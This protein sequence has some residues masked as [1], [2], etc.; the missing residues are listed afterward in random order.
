MG[1]ALYSQTY[2]APAPVVTIRTEPEITPQPCE[3]WS[4]W[5]HF[6]PDSE[7]FFQDAEYEAFID[8]AQYAREQLA[9]ARAD[10]LNDADGDAASDASESSEGG[11]SAGN[12]ESPM[13]VGADDPAVLIA[14]IYT[15][16]SARWSNGSADAVSPTDP[17]WSPQT[18][19]SVNT[20][21]SS[22]PALFSAS[23]PASE[24]SPAFIPPPL[25]HH[26]TRSPMLRRMPP[27]T[28]ITITRTQTQTRV[29]DADDV[30]FLM[31]SPTPDSSAPSTPLPGDATFF[32]PQSLLTPSPPPS[33]TPR[34]YAWQQYT[35]PTVA[36]PVSPTR[37]RSVARDG[38]L[39]NP[40]ARMSYIRIDAP[41]ARIRIPNT[42]M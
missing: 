29:S 10:N 15:N 6:D 1:R 11:V 17:E 40:R 4:S 33:V 30:D 9:S 38:P 18:A 7:E 41:P 21:T 34:F 16:H 13:A 20:S 14:D 26:V 37:I 31:R 5:D 3:P 22:I 24:Y 8:P 23:S 42:V 25:D 27:I 39:T 2:P 36:T 19:L 28:P 12:G 32:P 35:V